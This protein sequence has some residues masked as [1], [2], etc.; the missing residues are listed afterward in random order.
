ME[1]MVVDCVMG[2]NKKFAWS[3]EF[4]LGSP[5]SMS[6]VT[7]TLPTTPPFFAPEN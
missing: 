4:A 3:M 7:N 2:L 1:L 6:P 5:D